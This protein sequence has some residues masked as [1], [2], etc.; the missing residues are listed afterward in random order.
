MAG[1]YVQIATFCREVKRSEA[2]N[3]SVIDC[4]AA[5]YAP[6]PPGNAPPGAVPMVTLDELTLALSLWAGE[7]VGDYTITI[8]P[9]PPVGEEEAITLQASF[10]K[11]AVG[12]G[13]DFAVRF[14][15]TKVPGGSYWFRVSISGGPK[16]EAERP[17]VAVPLDIHIVDS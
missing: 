9:D 13:Q 2:G 10:P 11:A 14:G 3:L 8:R 1:P 17:V 15:G 7:L 5:I 6:L 16:D 12:V 4:V